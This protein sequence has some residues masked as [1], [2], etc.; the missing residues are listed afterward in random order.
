[1]VISLVCVL[2]F[3]PSCL[4]ADNPPD[5]MTDYS[6][7]NFAIS[8]PYPK[9]WFVKEHSDG[10]SKQVFISEREIKRPEDMFKTGITITKISNY[11]KYFGYEFASS[12]EAA[13]QIVESHVNDFME[14]AKDY[15]LGSFG[16]AGSDSR[17]RPF[18]ADLRFAG[19]GASRVREYIFVAYEK[20]TLVF[21]TMEAP[22]SEFLRYKNLYDTIIASIKVF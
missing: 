13:K 20:N 14:N 10:D 8:T 5:N 18:I 16:P 2:Y 17:C 9:G 22:D 7:N 6:N 1:M 4:F 21:I 12:E 11:S 19:E 15:Y 3:W